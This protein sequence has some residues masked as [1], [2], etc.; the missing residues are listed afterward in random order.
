M[1]AGQSAAF[2]YDIGALRTPAAEGRSIWN[3]HAGTKK[4][5]RWEVAGDVF[6]VACVELQK[7]CR[8][9]DFECCVLSLFVYHGFPSRNTSSHCFYAQ[10]DGSSVTILAFDGAKSSHRLQYARNAVKRMKSFRH[11]NI[12]PYLDG[13]EVGTTLYVVTEEVTAL[14]E[15]LL[16]ELRSSAQATERIWGLHSILVMDL[17]YIR[18]FLLTALF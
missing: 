12:L 4:V 17:C 18:C 2:P 10:T 6:E 5:R 9:L 16:A 3:V 13:T 14:G 11:P 8:F 15:E 7:L 1:G